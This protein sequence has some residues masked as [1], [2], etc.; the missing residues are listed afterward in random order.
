MHWELLQNVHIFERIILI[1]LILSRLVILIT[2]VSFYT[3]WLI[4]LVMLSTSF[5][6][7]SSIS[8]IDN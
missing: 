7:S 2:D 5:I 4:L 6:S 8:F 1:S 3:T